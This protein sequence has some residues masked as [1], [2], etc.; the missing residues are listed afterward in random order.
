MFYGPD[1]RQERAGLEVVFS[2]LYAL[3][4]VSE[5]FVLGLGADG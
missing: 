1:F 3:V 4:Q 2:D 5:G